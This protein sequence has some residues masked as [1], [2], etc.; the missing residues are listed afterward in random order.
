MSIYT[1][2]KSFNNKR[3]SPST[4]LYEFNKELIELHSQDTDTPVTRKLSLNFNSL[5]ASP[6][7]KTPYGVGW[8]INGLSEYTQGKKLI[9]SNGNSFSFESLTENK[10]SFHDQK[11]QDFSVFKRIEDSYE[12][13]FI[14]YKDGVIEVLKNLGGGG[15]D[16][17]FRLSEIIF[18]NGEIYHFEHNA[19]ISG[20]P[21]LSKIYNQ[22]NIDLVRFNYSNMVLSSIEVRQNETT[23]GL[24][25]ISVTQNGSYTQLDWIG[26]L[27][28]EDDPNEKTQFQYDEKEGYLIV[29]RT[30]QP[31]GAIEELQYTDSGHPFVVQGGQTQYIP[32]I[33]KYSLY[34]G[35]DQPEI[36][37]TYSYS[38]HNFLG[39]PNSNGWSTLQDNLYLWAS[40]NDYSYSITI[41]TGLGEQLKTEV[42]TY[43]TFHL[44]TQYQTFS[45]QCQVTVHNVYLCDEAPYADK[46]L[47]LQPNNVMFP[48]KTT[49]T[50]SDG[51]K[52]AHFVTEMATDDFGNQLE[53]KAPTGIVESYQYYPVEGEPDSCPPDPFKLF[54]R[55]LKTMET[56]SQDG[57]ISKTKR[58]NYVSLTP[59]KAA[60]DRLKEAVK[61]HLIQYGDKETSILKAEFDYIN[62]PSSLYTHNAVTRIQAGMLDN[63]NSLVSPTEVTLTYSAVKDGILTLEKTL[64]GYNGNIASMSEST[65]VYTGRPVCQIDTNGVQHEAI[66]DVRGRITRSSSATETQWQRNDTYEYGYSTETKTPQVLYTDANGQQ[67][68][69]RFDGMNRPLSVE[70]HAATHQQDINEGFRKIQQFGYDDQGRKALEIALDYFPDGTALSSHSI[71]YQYDDWGQ[72]CGIQNGNG[73]IDAIKND[74]LT[75]TQS[76]RQEL[77]SDIHDA[78]TVSAFLTETLTEYDLFKNPLKVETKYDTTTLCIT[79]NSYDGIGRK[80]KVHTPLGHETSV[81]EYDLFDRIIKTTSFDEQHYQAS[82]SDF[83]PQQLITSVT[84]EL[85]GGSKVNLGEQVFDDLGRLSQKSVSGLH[86]TFE[87][88]EASDSPTKVTTASGN[89]I[90]FERIAELNNSVNKVSTYL[91]QGDLESSNEFTFADNT[92]SLINQGSLISS[93]NAVSGYQYQYDN[94][95]NVSAVD[96]SVAEHD[97]GQISART[98][99]LLGKPLSLEIK[100]GDTTVARQHHYDEL[101]RLVS[102]TQGN[103]TVSLEYD[104]FSRIAVE[105]IQESGNVRQSTTIEYD[106]WGRESARHCHITLNNETSLLTLLSHYDAENKLSTRTTRLNDE[107]RL[108]EHFS[109][110][111][112]NRLTQYWIDEGYDPS[113]LPINEIGLKLISQNF[114]YDSFNNITSVESK[115]DGQTTS[116]VATYHFDDPAT[117]R[118]TAIMHTLV[119]TFPERIDLSYDE[120]G[121]LILIDQGNSSTSLKYSVEGRVTAINGTEYQYDPYGRLITNTLDGQVH[122]YLGETLFKVVS[123]V[124][125]NIEFIHSGQQTV[126]EKESNVTR[127]LSSTQQGTVIASHDGNATNNTA[128]TPYGAAQLTSQTGFNGEILDKTTNAYFLGNGTRLY[129]PNLGL[130]SS[131]DSMTPFSGGGINPYFYCNGDPIN[132]SDPTGHFSTEADLALNVVCFMGDLLALILAPFTGGSSAAIAMGMS[133]AAL[134]LISDTL[135]IAADSMSIKDEKNHTDHSDKIQR[136]GLASGIFGVASIAVGAGDGIY[137]ANKARQGNKFA[138]KADKAM[139]LFKLNKEF[140]ASLDKLPTKRRENHLK[141]RQR[142][143]ACMR[144]NKANYDKYY[145]KGKAAD[146]E[147]SY[148]DALNSLFANLSGVD[149]NYINTTFKGVKLTK[150]A[151]AEGTS[152]AFDMVTVPSGYALLANTTWELP[153]ATDNGT[154]SDAEHM[155]Q[156]LA[157]TIALKYPTG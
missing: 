154:N 30:E 63:N 139:G 155:Q 34:P 18:P 36:Q 54:S 88:T 58:F 7:V 32:R 24:F 150:K 67:A 129:L 53:K 69:I 49:V 112:L 118:P 14:Y 109:Y 104:A 16:T 138:K 101:G 13:Y 74:P 10:V 91:K 149:V 89:T 77:R 133:A 147:G 33:T 132:L 102:T 26:H 22:D 152:H 99:S 106:G 12:R 105:E 29:T 38:E 50:F 39:F 86:T 83:S 143:E 20:I 52:E 76:H 40:A 5:Q 125:E 98:Y 4:G 72:I 66:Y 71:T 103:I 93:K 111:C 42:Y 80:T 9:L 114:E 156:M 128:Y 107:D 90:Q 116:D 87:Y 117:R 136:L 31:E 25:N 119:S 96:Q 134:G 21:Y 60:Q 48:T 81:E 15:V 153:S 51:I 70:N 157:Q 28:N 6:L 121:N 145:E 135:G 1:Q 2:V 85:S 35:C 97:S 45:N 127:V 46:E 82:Y 94:D 3:V 62:S 108:T 19:F 79:E 59:M 47:A 23:M 61:V 100:I 151:V 130:F 43:N 65:N 78:S 57:T 64:V 17:I 44:L 41:K 95:G 84:L 146:R 141:M 75:L 137:K 144:R 113:F 56:R 37:Q 8:H 122:Y 124:N 142:N 148:P 92:S 27:K 140:Q 120:D 11:T 68:R 126:A 55:F 110:D 73:V 115:F 131:P 123:A